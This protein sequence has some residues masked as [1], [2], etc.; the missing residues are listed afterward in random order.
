MLSKE[1]SSWGKVTWEKDEQ[2]T[3]WSTT[4]QGYC[5]GLSF[6]GQTDK[7]IVTLRPINTRGTNGGIAIRIPMNQVSD[8]IRCLLPYVPEFDRAIILGLV[9]ETNKQKAKQ[10]CQKINNQL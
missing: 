1:L 3:Y 8:I 9:K 2:I 7:E 6:V 5:I 4:R 10:L